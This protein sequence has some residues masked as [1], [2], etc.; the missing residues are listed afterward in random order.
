LKSNN[1]LISGATGLIG[2]HLVPHLERKGHTVLRLTRN[3]SNDNDIRW[4]LKSS[5]IELSSA[6]QLDAVIHLAGENITHR[7]WSKSQK[8]RIL[9]SRELG[10]RLLSESIAK[11]PIPP[12]V[13]ISASGIN[14]YDQD[15][16]DPHTED[17]P[18]GKR[19]LSTVCKRWEESTTPALEAN[20]R[21]CIMRIGVVLTPAGGALK[22]MLPSIKLGLGGRIGSGLQRM[23]WI[24]I[25]DLV[26]MIY[27]AT[28]DDRW[29]GPINAVADEP[30]TNKE[31]TNLLAKL[32]KRPALLPVPEFFIKLLFGQMAEETLLADLPVYS[33]RRQKLG[34][35]LTYPSLHKALTHLIK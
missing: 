33:E 17:S 35:E 31:F 25:D 27:E 9:K 22:K 20:I 15:S 1:I 2:K 28:L 12:K 29:E 32:L 4:D 26:G 3:P 24:S 5:S 21:V 13:L 23:S 6:N 10:T 30:V 34:Y 14:Y 19:F 16:N 11:L 8:E 7:R 18:P